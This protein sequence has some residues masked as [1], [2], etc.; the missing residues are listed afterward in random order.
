MA[1]MYFL[2]ECHRKESVGT[3]LTRLY[4]EPRDK[5]RGITRLKCT[6]LLRNGLITIGTL[7]LRKE[8]EHRTT[9]NNFPTC[10]VA[11]SQAGDGEKGGEG[12]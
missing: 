10:A 4:L 8:H 9:Q 1:A 11:R 6:F 7:K 5:Y 2:N 12:M 3:M